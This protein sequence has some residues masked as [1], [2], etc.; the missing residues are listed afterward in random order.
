MSSDNSTQEQWTSYQDFYDG[1]VNG[2]LPIL[3]LTI[4]GPKPS[5]Y[6]GNLAYFIDDVLVFGLL[7]FGPF[8][9]MFFIETL[10]EKYILGLFSTAIIYGS[11]AL[12]CSIS[13]YVTKRNKPFMSTR[14]LMVIYFP[15]AILFQNIAWTIFSFKSNTMTPL[16]GK[17][18]SIPILLLN[19]MVYSLK[20]KGFL[21]S[22]IIQLIYQMI[23]LSVFLSNNYYQTKTY[24]ALTILAVGRVIFYIT[25]N[26]KNED[27]TDNV[28]EET[29]DVYGFLNFCLINPSEEFTE[30]E[31]MDEIDRKISK[32]IGNLL[33]RIR[34][35]FK[36]IGSKELEEG[37]K[38]DSKESEEGSNIVIDENRNPRIDLRI[39]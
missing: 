36:R 18:V 14:L 20:F 38:E 15:S 35:I 1:C 33:K 21:V 19:Y 22:I 4:Y 24:I 26:Q 5:P 7:L 9:A 31:E 2:L 10:K 39:D 37:S 23:W 6:L 27:E 25:E 3:F 32:G 16:F 8:T 13:T 17:I 28:N 34:K 11:F 12:I 30:E 29:K